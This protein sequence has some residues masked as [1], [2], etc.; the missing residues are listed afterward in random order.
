MSLTKYPLVAASLVLALS[1][2]LGGVAGAG[3][4]IANTVPV[5]SAAVDED[6]GPALVPVDFVDMPARALPAAGHS[7]TF[8]MAYRNDSSA[9]QIVAPQILV[10]SSDAGPFLAPTD[11]RAER[12]SADGSRV[13]VP[14]GSQ[15]G[16]LFTDLVAAQRTLH[17]GESLTE[18]YRV[19]VPSSGAV[20]TVQPHVALCG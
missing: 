14:V 11:V 6:A 7:H 19:T 13:T 16:T 12:W 17:P 4:A 2:G 15:T 8:V 20:G 3:P 10:E 9:D 18:R 1:S 5:A